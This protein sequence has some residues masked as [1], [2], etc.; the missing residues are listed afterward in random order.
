[1]ILRQRGSLDLTLPAFAI[2]PPLFQRGDIFPVSRKREKIEYLQPI[3]RVDEWSLRAFARMPSTA[4]FLRARAE[5]KNLLCELASN[6]KIWGAR[7]SEHS[8]KFCEHSKTTITNNT[9]AQ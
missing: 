2:C 5:I 9:C 4:I 7:A 8:F 3:C 6:T 1:M